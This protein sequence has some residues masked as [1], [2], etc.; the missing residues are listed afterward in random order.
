MTH[1]HS[2]DKAGNHIVVYLMHNNLCNSDHSFDSGWL[3]QLDVDS[4]K[5]AR[6]QVEKR[7]VERAFEMMAQRTPG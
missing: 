4:W 6:L 7:K 3:L 2:D 5:V 1:P